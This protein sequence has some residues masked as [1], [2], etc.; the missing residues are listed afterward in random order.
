VV[1]RRKEK[2][3]E[4]K[5]GAENQFTALLPKDGRRK[6]IPPLKA[7]QVIFNFRSKGRGGKGRKNG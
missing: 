2:K 1:T 5:R 7:S 4:K 6:K 3:R